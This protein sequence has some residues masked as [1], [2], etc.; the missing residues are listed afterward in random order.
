MKRT[1]RLLS[2]LLTLAGVLAAAPPAGAGT[3][4][5]QY[6]IEPDPDFCCLPW[7]NQG[8]EIT[9]GSVTWRLPAL[10]PNT[11]DYDAAYADRASLVSFSIFG[12]SLGLRWLP[13][14]S[15][16]AVLYPA[17]HGVVQPTQY[18]VLYTFVY[19]QHHFQTGP[20]FS[21]T[22]SPMP[23]RGRPFA[24]LYPSQQA[25]RQVWSLASTYSF[26]N[27]DA[28][29]VRGLEVSRTFVP[30]PAPSVL[31]ALG[32]ALLGLCAWAFGRRRPARMG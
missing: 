15:A 17:G 32:G 10:G 24:V 16:R 20:S 9:G 21:A 3:L 6:A 4:T 31:L 23:L 30:E 22:P 26:E 5:I 12:P 8:G 28:V 25:I 27:Y 29:R 18:P 19:R 11:L 14:V 7:G 1:A 2:A 13:V